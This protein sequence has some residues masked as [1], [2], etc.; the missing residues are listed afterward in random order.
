[1]KTLGI[2]LILAAVLLVGG[3]LFLFFSPN[4]TS[5][6]LTPPH[7]S[8]NGAGITPYPGPVTTGTPVVEVF[9]DYQCPGCDTFHSTYGP[10]LSQAAQAGRID[11]R[12]RTFVSTSKTT[13]ASSTSAA[14]A[15][16]CA[17][18]VGAYPAYHDLLLTNQPGDGAY[19][20]E[21][22]RTTIPDQIGMTPTQ[23]STFR[24]CFDRQMTHDFVVAADA[25]NAPATGPR[26]S[27]N[28][29]PL[30]VAPS[31]TPA[32]LLDAINKAKR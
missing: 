7:V 28:G 4:N 1:M 3:A 16:A 15:A 9:S 2:I 23:G 20:T 19:P 11:L 30:A 12:Y 18:F 25:A 26:I 17:D 5:S 10:A 14:M 8:S 24:T 27:V 6:Q 29:K 13:T 32:Q 21:L 31:L 22:L